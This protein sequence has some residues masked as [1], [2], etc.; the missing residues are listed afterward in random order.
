MSLT[1]RCLKRLLLPGLLFAAVTCLAGC[2]GVTPIKTVLDDPSQYND[3]SVTIAGK[4][5]SSAGLLGLGAYKV[6]DGTGSLTV[7]S[8]STG[9][10]REGADVVVQGKVKLAYSLGTESATVMLEE[11]RKTR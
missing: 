7:V 4:V 9:A 8:G 1:D 11:K 5:T 3:R 10:P 6:D 2:Q